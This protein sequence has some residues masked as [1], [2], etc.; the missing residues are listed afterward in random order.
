[1][2]VFM[3]L[4]V[5]WIGQFCCDVIGRQNV[6]VAVIGQLL[7]CCYFLSVCCLLK[8]IVHCSTAVHSYDI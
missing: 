3:S 4:V 1:M 2:M 6:K 8:Y 7:F 5:D